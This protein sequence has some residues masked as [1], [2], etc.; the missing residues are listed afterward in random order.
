M[1]LF[2]PA[3][4]RVRVKAAMLGYGSRQHEH[5]GLIR[6]DV[7]FDV[8]A[9]GCGGFLQVPGRFRLLPGRISL[10]VQDG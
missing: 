3:V 1:V 10:S 5:R 4:E 7:L 2:E 6:R 9:D 8:E